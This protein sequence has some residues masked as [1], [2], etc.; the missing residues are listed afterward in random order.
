MTR[1]STRIESSWDAASTPNKKC[2][3]M[4]VLEEI[5]DRAR[6]ELVLRTE[7]GSEDTFLLEHSVRVATSTRL[8]A[9]LP[10]VKEQQPDVT[11]LVAAALFH[12]SGWVLRVQDREM[13]RAEVLNSPPSPMLR[14]QSAMIMEDRLQRIVPA[15]SLHVA[16]RAIRSLSDRTTDLIECQVLAEADNLEE[17]GLLALWPAGRRNTLDGKCVQAAIDTWHRRKEYQ[18]WAARIK[19]SFRYPEVR[20]LAEIRLAT[21]ERAMH[22]LEEQHR[23]TDVADA[24]GIPAPEAFCHRTG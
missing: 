9:E 1:D 3:L 15:L 6:A 4:S 10:A 11:A 24:L 7:Q 20:K 13:R 12:E 8:I 22:E 16:A 18:Y 19:D 21:Y 23:G 5:W 17:F 14:D 2:R